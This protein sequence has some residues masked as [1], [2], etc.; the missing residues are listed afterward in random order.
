MSFSPL[1]D[2]HRIRNARTYRVSSFDKSGGNRDFVS[3][4]PLAE[5]QVA[6]IEGPAAVKHIWMTLWSDDPNIRR[7]L[8]LE[9]RWDGNEEPSVRAPI[10]D[11]FGQG[12]SLSYNFASLPLSAA[13]RSGGSLVSY[14]PMPFK[15]SADIRVINE[16]EEPIRGFYFY[17]DIEELPDTDDIGYFHAWFNAESTQNESGDGLENAWIQ[18]E[19]DPKNLD[20]NSNYLFCDVQGQGHF[21]GV[22]L[23]VQAPSTPWPGEG[24]DMFFID[25]EPWP[26]SFHGTGT[27]D[28]FNTAWGPDEVFCHPYFGIAYAPGRNNDDPRFGWIGRMHYYRFHIEDPIRFSRSLT[29]GIEH[30]HANGMELDLSSVAYWYTSSPKG[31]P[32]L[33]P[34]ASRVPRR[35][36]SPEDIHRWRDAWRRQK[37]TR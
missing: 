6:Q 31:V 35:P 34:A 8:V 22:N 5:H 25:G 19:P 2:I 21:V 9:I 11:F 27:E 1:G 28:Y 17:V 33:P 3:I 7:K 24:D 37:G 12:W 30:G 15:E 36:T 14:F 10:G 13:P 4:E 18:A 29:A 16:S 23:Y 26:T 20:G 32:L